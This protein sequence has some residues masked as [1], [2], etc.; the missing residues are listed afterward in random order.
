MAKHKY[1]ETPEKLWELFTEYRTH[2]KSNPRTKHV[3]V[4]KDGK[5]DYELLEVPL[6][7]EG[8]DNFC[9]EKGLTIEHYFRN[10]NKAYED[11]CGICMRVRN[12]IRQDQIEGGMVGQYNPSI[13]QRLNGLTEKQQIEQT[14]I[15]KFDFDGND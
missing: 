7:M 5:S 15:E 4:G 2:V 11:Y 8:F 10:T 1:I 13:T 3:F 9:Y 12:A 6:T 14:I